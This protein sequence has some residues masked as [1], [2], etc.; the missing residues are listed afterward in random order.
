MLD[1]F[2]FVGLPYLAIVVC[3]VGCIWRSRCDRYSMSARSSQFLEDGRLLFGS[4]PWHVGI[5]IVLL[6]HLI[7]AF[8]PRVWSSLMSVPGMLFGAEALGVACSVLAIVGLGTLIVRRVTDARVQAVTTTMDLVLVVLLMAQIV[9]GL[10]SAVSFRHGAAWSTGTVVPYFW[11]LFTLHPDMA[12]V[13]GFPMLF[14]LH[15]VGAWILIA[16]VP[17]T[18]LM[19]VLAVPLGYIFR[20]PQI[21]IWNNPRRRREAIEAT[22]QAESR[23]DFIKGAIGI[24]GGSGLLALGVSEKL[25]TYF[26][27]P[28]ADPE[29]ESALLRKKLER[30]QLTAEER[31][32][33]LERQRNTMILVA[34]YPDLD[35]VKG[36]YFIDYAMNPAL[37]F[38]GK[39]GLPLVISA[40]CT[41]LGCTVGSQINE[42]GEILCPCHVSY[43]NVITGQPNAG[44]PAKVPLPHI[45]WALVDAA[46]KVV[47]SRESGGSSEG[48]ADPASLAQLNLFITKPKSGKA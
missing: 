7:A 9:V 44:A 3:V 23:R 14:K 8:L 41:H 13:S 15:I 11:G 40:K 2:L 22:A 37:A 5:I 12:Y 45:A 21:V 35:E 30:L 24:A 4:L 31:Q 27:G 42:R 36:K 10:L 39:D 25:A 48:T 18:R 33:E 43:F 47:V 20:L 1:A 17:F 34:R 38:K 6:G 19:H 46:G 16:L 28:D 26:K 29:A 32:L